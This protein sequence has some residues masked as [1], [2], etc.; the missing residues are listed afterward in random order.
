M[1]EFILKGIAMLLF[2]DFDTTI[3]QN[4]VGDAF[5]RTFGDW[6]ACEAAIKR[7]ERNEISSREVLEIAALN[8]R[9]TRE[10]FEEFCAAQSLANGFIEFVAFCKERHWPIHILSDGLD[11]YIESILRRHDLKLPVYSNRLE[12]IA[13]ERVRVSFPFWEESC[14]RCANCKR[15]HVQRLAR[16]GVRRVYIGDGFSDRCGAREAEI[17]FAKDHLARWCEEEGR[18]FSRFED[19]TD[20]L[21][22]MRAW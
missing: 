4:D 18:R 19:F 10:Q 17:V 21:A 2:L 20:V 15:Q 6:P 7:W 12:W 8:T 14:G 22:K 5:F 11:A 13:P 3:A 16:E 9:V 1:G